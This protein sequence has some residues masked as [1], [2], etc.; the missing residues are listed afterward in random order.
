[1]DC[2]Y[3]YQYLLLKATLSFKLGLAELFQSS[4]QNEEFKEFSDLR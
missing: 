1:M 4:T 2:M 3:T